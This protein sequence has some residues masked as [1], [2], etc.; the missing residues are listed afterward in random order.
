MDG[1]DD[2]KLLLVHGLKDSLVTVSQSWYL[3]QELIKRGILFTQMV[4]ILIRESK[5]AVFVEHGTLSIFIDA[6][7]II[8]YI[9]P[10]QGLH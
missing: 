10:I 9:N 5:N 2:G 3:S 8:S 4:R 1:I 6:H 7:F